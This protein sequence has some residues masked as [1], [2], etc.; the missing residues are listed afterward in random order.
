LESRLSLICLWGVSMIC[1]K[2]LAIET[3]GSL[4]CRK[5]GAQLSTGIFQKPPAA[6]EDG[7]QVA[8]PR[9]ASSSRAKAIALAVFV[10]AALGLV[11]ALSL[12]E[13]TVR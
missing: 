3:E 6:P 4:R 12:L 5:C 10:A 8:K 13:R 11:I 9:E 1:P 7:E 2:C